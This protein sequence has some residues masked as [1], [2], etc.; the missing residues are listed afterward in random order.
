MPDQIQDTQ[1]PRPGQTQWGPPIAPRK[2]RGKCPH[3]VPRKRR[4][5]V[6]YQCGY[7][8]I[9]QCR[10]GG[11]VSGKVRRDRTLKRDRRIQDLAGIKTALEVAKMFTLSERQIYRI[12][13]YPRIPHVATAQR[14]AAVRLFL[15]PTDTNIFPVARNARQ[16]LVKLMC[17]RWQAQQQ[18]D[19]ATDD[20]LKKR[21]LSLIRKCSSE[22][23]RYGRAVRRGDGQA[24]WDAI[25]ADSQTLA[26]HHWEYGAAWLRRS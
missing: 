4:N 7:Y 24:E 23:T 6:C 17:W 8:T 25:L 13:K 22:I 2:G 3:G 9:R 14:L 5:R 18:R 19:A 21:F 26:A 20:R 15:N 1:N 10:N 16:A 11:L 12:W